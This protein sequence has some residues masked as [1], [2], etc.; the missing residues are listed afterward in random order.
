MDRQEEQLMQARQAFQEGKWKAALSV[1]HD[2]LQDDPACEEARDLLAEV[3]FRNRLDRKRPARARQFIIPWGRIGL[4][5]GIAVFLI[6]ALSLGVRLYREQLMPNVQAAQVQNRRQALL[7]QAQAYY[8]AGNFVMSQQ[9]LTALL[10]E[11]PDHQEALDLEAQIE[12]ELALV[13]KY[14]RAVALQAEGDPLSALELLVQLTVEKPGYRDVATRI[15]SIR[16]QTQRDDLFREAEVA[17]QQGDLVRALDLYQQVQYL[18]ASFSPELLRERIYQLH[19]D[20]ANEL[21]ARQPPEPSRLPDA[22]RHFQ[23]ALVLRPRDA[24][25]AAG[26]EVVD[27]FLEGRARFDEGQWSEAIRPLRRV[28]ELRP[29]FFRTAVLDMLYQAY[30]S[31]GDAYLNSGDVGMAYAAYMDANGLPLNDTALAEKRIVDIVPFLTPT[32]TP[33]PTA[34]PT[35]TLTP[36]PPAL[37][38]GV[39]TPRPL[40]AYHNM[41]VFSSDHEDQPGYW[42]V[43]PDGTQRT[44]LGRSGATR[45]EFEE[46]KSQQ[47]FSPDG[48]WQLVVQDVNRVAQIFVIDP[49][50]T[51]FP[52]PQPRQLTKMGGLCY[53]PAWS[54]DGGRIVFVSQAGQSDDIWV[55]NADGTS[56]RNLTAN[57]WQWDKHPSWSPDSSRI[58]FWSNRDGR[59]QI[60]V[61]DDQGR[62]ARNISNNEY[63]EYDPIWVR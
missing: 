38:T 13:A 20:I 18:D 8:V 11:V 55:M 56:A 32:L 45:R 16:K 22:Q 48:K 5:V 14:E 52:N 27:T 7:S 44:Y 21:M 57:A 34:T 53:D 23:Q 29:S 41:I 43:A 60:Y 12:A 37:P 62:N 33:S 58:V 25:A 46:L 24:V 50:T 36:R 47:A 26:K 28:F 49:P 35:L 63:N 19:I 39:P 42:V 61:M 31:M 15:A 59:N 54:P 1:L 3:E 6:L 10:Q 2:I 40:N 30:V 4:V 9:R 51:Q 17:Q